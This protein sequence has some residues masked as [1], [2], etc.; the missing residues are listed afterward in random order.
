M[1]WT[2]AWA[3][4]EIVDG[5]VAPFAPLH[6]A[7]ADVGSLRVE[8]ERKRRF[9][10]DQRHVLGRGRVGFDLDGERFDRGESKAKR[11]NSDGCFHASGIRVSA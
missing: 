11:D 10:L 6:I 7:V 2:R 5:Q 3:S 9:R 1:K 8:F 4:V